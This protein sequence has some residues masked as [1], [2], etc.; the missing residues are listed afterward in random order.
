MDA[1]RTDIVLQYALAV[2]SEADDYFDRWLGKIH[3]L[4][5][6]YI[7]DLAYASKHGATFT[8]ASWRFYHYGPWD[9]AVCDRIEPV[10]AYLGAREFIRQNSKYDSDFAGWWI[11]K[12]EAKELLRTL[13]KQLPIEVTVEVKRA[14]R[15][16]GND[17]TS[18]LHHVYATSP[19]LH[20][21]PGQTLDFT[22]AKNARSP[23]SSSADAN[24]REPT[25]KELKRRKADMLKL[26]EKLRAAT[27]A[28]GPRQR[29]PPAIQPIYDEVFFKGA[30]QIDE[31]AGVSADGLSGEAALSDEIWTSEARRR[32]QLP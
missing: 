26:K 23:V 6:V 30:R 7:A 12:D 10:V 20:A 13:D 8:G 16:F 29:K 24:T 28:P 4:K 15:S 14:V 11:N 17:T 31:L 5:Y 21:A 22:I 18:L 3:L 32:G 19:M 27:A 1:A 25:A 9:M 2:A